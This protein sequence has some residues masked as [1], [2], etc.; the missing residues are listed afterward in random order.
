[1]M[2]QK[3]SFALVLMIVV[4]CPKLW[5]T[6][7]PIRTPLWELIAGADLILVGIPHVPLESL[8]EGM[9]GNVSTAI[10]IDVT[11]EEPL[12]GTSNMAPLHVVYWP[13]DDGYRPSPQVLRDVNG[14]RALFFLDEHDD[15]RFNFA[16]HTPEALQPFDDTMLARIQQEITYQQDVLRR[17]TQDIQPSDLAHYDRVKTLIR[18]LRK[19]N[20]Q[21]ENFQHLE[22][23]GNEAVPAIIY[24]MDDFRK[25]PIQQISLTCPPGWFEALRHYSPERVVDALAAILNQLTGKSFGTMIY[26]GDVSNKERKRTIHGWRIYLHYRLLEAQDLPGK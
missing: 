14:K 20:T 6:E 24:L 23:L 12:K 18:D 4:V 10:T 11:P 16:G 7:L 13:K 8:Q 9:N 22:A 25:L 5:C 17:F 1:M 19:R 15:D 2:K 3:V 21:L 26:N